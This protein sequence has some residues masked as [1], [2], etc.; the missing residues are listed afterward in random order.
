V[1]LSVLVSPTRVRHFTLAW[2][3]DVE[4]GGMTRALLRRSG[5]FARAFGQTVT[6]LTFDPDRDYARI[7]TGLDDRGLL[8]DGVELLN[9][10]DWLAA[11]GGAPDTPRRM[12][13]RFSADGTR[14]LQIDHLRPDG[15]VAVSDERDAPVRGHRRVRLYSPDGVVVREWRTAW[16][17]YA[18]WL[19]ALRDGGRAVMVADSKPAA[20]FLATYRR[21]EVLTAH[22]MH[23]SHL[24]ADGRDL[25]ATRRPVVEAIDDYDLVAVLTR[26]QRADLERRI[27]RRRNLRVIPNVVDPVAE[28]LANPGRHGG[29]VL[30]SLV[31]RKRV[32]HAVRAV[33]DARRLGIRAGLDIYGDGPHRRRVEALA[34]GT[35]GVHLHGFR[36]GASAALRDHSFLLLTSTSEGSPLCVLEALA[37]GCLPIAYDIPFGPGD[38]IRDG[39]TGFLVAPGDI[40]ALASRI[41]Q[42]EA[43]PKP[44][45]DA[46]RRRAVASVARYAEGVVLQLWRREL[47]AAWYR[48]TGIIPR[49]RRVLRRRFATAA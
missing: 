15:S 35:D 44:A 42:L 23:G 22:V 46:M 12:T 6:I 36:S 4:H 41:A 14:L 28:P 33:A 47:A 30:A 48:K 29:I 7:R 20:R 31:G 49:A 1:T 43:M 9:L 38:A 32:D 34:R 24:D 13:R 25:S 37:A 8:P 19:D 18:F 10:W 16:A 5:M 26:Q 11:K 39:V 17:L 40:A 2:A 45:V 27:G 21:R 3:L